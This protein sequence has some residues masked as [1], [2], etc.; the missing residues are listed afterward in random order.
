[1]ATRRRL[2]QT[3]TYTYDG[4]GNRL[5]HVV[6]KADGKIDTTCTYKSRPVPH[7]TDVCYRKLK[8]K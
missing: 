2:E 3:W 1:M 7:D 8:C 5:Q 6:T 4:E